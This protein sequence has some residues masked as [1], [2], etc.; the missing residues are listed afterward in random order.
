[1]SRDDDRRY[2]HDVAYEVWRRGG[3]ADYVDYDRMSNY[4]D[5]GLDVDQAAAAE[6]Q[7]QRPRPPEPDYQYDDGPAQEPPDCPAMLSPLCDVCGQ[8]E[9]VTGV[10]GYG[11]CSEECAHKAEDMEA[12]SGGTDA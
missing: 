7:R 6:L 1:M 2:E 4:R 8:H 9:A 11:V 3:N 10:N 5:C 12:K